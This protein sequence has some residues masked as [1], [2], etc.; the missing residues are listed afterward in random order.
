MYIYVLIYLWFLPASS[1]A[2][3]SAGSCCTNWYSRHASIRLAF[4]CICVDVLMC[5]GVYMYKYIYNHIFMFIYWHISWWSKLHSSHMSIK[6]CSDCECMCT[7][8]H[9]YIFA[10]KI[11]CTLVVKTKIHQ[12]LNM[13]R[14]THA[15]NS[16]PHTNG[17]SLSSSFAL[18]L[19]C[20]LLPWRDTHK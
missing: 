20:T 2:C 14:R 6:V 9:V 13:Y 7:C 3:L 19:P 11:E 15:L 1:R 12:K 10:L 17:L 5:K 18:S 8:L 16:H 4:D